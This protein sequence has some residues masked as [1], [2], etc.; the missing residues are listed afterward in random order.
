MFPRHISLKVPQ[1]TQIW[2]VRPR[3]KKFSPL[4]RKK[5]E[6][7]YWDKSKEFLNV[8][9]HTNQNWVRRNLKQQVSWQ[10]RVFS[11]V[12]N[13]K[14]G[15]LLNEMQSLLFEEDSFV[16][17]KKSDHFHN[18]WLVRSATSAMQCFFFWTLSLKTVLQIETGRLIRRLRK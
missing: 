18:F 15:T 5:N 6:F 4:F 2:R 1:R 8:D 13:K 11:Q 7:E 14:M 16:Y 17:R 3:C 12:F 10:S 9:S